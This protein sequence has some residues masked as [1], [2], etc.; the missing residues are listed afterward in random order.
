MVDIAKCSNKTCPMRETCYRYK[1][2]ANS[3]WQTY[4]AF[5]PDKNGNCRDYIKYDTE[6]GGDE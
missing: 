1:A 5:A 3:V 6:G 4:S 2:K